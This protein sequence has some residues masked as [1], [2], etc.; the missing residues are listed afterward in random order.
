MGQDIRLVEVSADLKDLVPGFLYNRRDEIFKS[1]SLV[2][3][4]DFVAL[5]RLGHA[6][7][8]A[9]MAFGFT[10]AT[11]MA[12]ALEMAAAESDRA[13]AEVQIGALENFFSDPQIRYV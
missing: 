1:R 6:F 2:E 8:G 5:K 9:C 10:K 11:Q 13:A 4:S 3:Q 12:T 7:K